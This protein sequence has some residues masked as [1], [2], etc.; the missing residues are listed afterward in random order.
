[1]VAGDEFRKKHLKRWSDWEGN[2]T[3]GIWD[4]DAES[5]GDAY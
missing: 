2:K 3:L 1:M 5:S 4:G